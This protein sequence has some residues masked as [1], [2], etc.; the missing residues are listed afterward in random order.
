[1]SKLN[2]L[3]EVTKEEVDSAVC[4]Y[5]KQRSLDLAEYEKRLQKWREGYKFSWWQKNVKKL[6]RLNAQ[7][8]LVELHG[9]PSMMG[10]NMPPRDSVKVELGLWDYSFHYTLGE[11][12]SIWRDAAIGLHRSDKESHLVS[13]EVLVWITTWKDHTF[14]E[15]E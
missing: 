14:E 12:G 9:W 10:Y 5:R 15:A 6:E 3:T 2:S 13:T 4:N 11:Y 1:M 8:L 7:D